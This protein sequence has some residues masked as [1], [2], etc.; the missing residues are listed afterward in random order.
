MLSIAER[1][2]RRGMADVSATSHEFHHQMILLPNNS[3][4]FDGILVSSERGQK[5]VLRWTLS[6]A[7]SG[8]VLILLSLLVKT[9][10]N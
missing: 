4:L 5:L 7:L 6:R 10:T 2:R 1:T 3:V 9:D 8:L